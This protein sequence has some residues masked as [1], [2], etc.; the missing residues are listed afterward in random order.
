VQPDTKPVQ[1]SPL[2]T[3]DAA[4]EFLLGNLTTI[5]EQELVPIMAAHKRVL[6]TT[7]VAPINVPSQANSAMDGY[8]V[9]AA[10]ATLNVTLPVTQRIAAGQ[11][12]PKLSRGEAAR[13]FTGAPMPEGADAVVMQEDCRVEG[14][15]IVILEAAHNGLNTRQV[16]EDLRAGDAVLAAGKRLQ[17]QDIGVLASLGLTEVLVKRQLRV[18]LMTTGDELVEPGQPLAPGQIY[19]SNFYTL[20][21]LL[22]ALGVDVLD[23]GV[24]SDDLDHTRQALQGVAQ[25]AD[26]II[27]TGGVSVG[28]EDHVKAALAEAGQ[29]SLWKLAIKPGKPL[30]YGKLGNA[31]FFGLPGNPVSAFVT[32]A[33]IVR[34][35]LLTML[36]CAHPF[37]LVMQSQSGMAYQT[38]NRQEYVRC[39]I[40]RDPA[41]TVQLLPFANQSSGVG[42]SLSGSDGLAVIPPYTSVAIGDTL[43]FVPFSE[44]MS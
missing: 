32:F 30:A 3:I 4:L 11:T 43:D 12:G 31:H 29:L 22:Q 10:D 36:G 9:H 8:A 42:A 33:L 35:C 7:I 1:K 2:T 17:A 23:C 20:S 24:V 39:R 27:S 34:P 14:D 38:G 16:G 15:R 40:Q 44:L 28:E 25:D 19:N 18:A 37:P 6:A 13:I 21:T 5:A 41:G 26:C